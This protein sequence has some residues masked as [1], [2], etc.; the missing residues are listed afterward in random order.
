MPV[1][2][3]SLAFLLV[4]LQVGVNFTRASLRLVGRALPLAL[5]VIVVLGSPARAWAPSSPARPASARWTATSPP[6]RA[7]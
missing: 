7:G 5:L 6:P 2:L 3:E 1:P 4:G